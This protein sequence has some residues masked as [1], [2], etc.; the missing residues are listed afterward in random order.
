[1]AIRREET[2]FIDVNGLQVA[3][4]TPNYDRPLALV[5]LEVLNRLASTLKTADLFRLKSALRNKLADVDTIE[6]YIGALDAE[7][8][9]HKTVNLI[10]EVA[11]REIKPAEPVGKLDLND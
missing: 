9:F 4:L 1:M 6:E 2:K 8:S 7:V 5:D 3:D 11:K 10:Q